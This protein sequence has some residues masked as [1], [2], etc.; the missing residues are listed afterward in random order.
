MKNA[1]LL[2]TVMVRPFVYLMLFKNN[3]VQYWNEGVLCFTKP[4]S[5]LD[6]AKRYFDEL[7]IRING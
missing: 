4:H 6:E 1:N 5:N 7:I 2:A 3:D